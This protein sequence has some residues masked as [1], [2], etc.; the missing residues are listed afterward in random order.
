M[1]D[2][3]KA[4]L[5]DRGGNVSVVQ[6]PHRHHPGIAI[7][8][9]TFYSL[10]CAIRELLAAARSGAPVEEDLAYLAETVESYRRYF[11]A[12]LQARGMTLPYASSDS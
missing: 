4:E 5:L 3:D 10:V 1:E 7:Q 2:S 8:G 12:V 11:E 6:L 9:D